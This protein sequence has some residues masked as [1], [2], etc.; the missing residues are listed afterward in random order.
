MNSNKNRNLVIINS[1]DYKSYLT[2][3]ANFIW[4]NCPSQG[5]GVITFEGGN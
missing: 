1:C 2:F 5:S 3:T 4:K